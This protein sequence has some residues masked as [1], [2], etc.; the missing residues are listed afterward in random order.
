M[1]AV[2]PFEEATL[3]FKNTYPAYAAN[4]SR[5]HL[6][7]AEMRFFS[8]TLLPDLSLGVEVVEDIQFQINKGSSEQGGYWN[9]PQEYHD[10]IRL[11]SEQEIGRLK[12]VDDAD[13]RNIDFAIHPVKYSPLFRSKEVNETVRLEAF[14]LR[15]A[16]IQKASYLDQIGTNITCLSPITSKGNRTFREIDSAHGQ[17]K[18]LENC[19]SANTIG[20][21]CVLLDD[22]GEC[23]LRWRAFNPLSAREDSVLRK[24]AVMQSGWHCSSS[25]VLTWSDIE[26]G[27]SVSQNES[28][29]IVNGFFGGMRREIAREIGLNANEYDLSLFAYGREFKRA[30]KPQLFFVAKLRQISTSQVPDVIKKRKPPE[31]DEFKDLSAWRNNFLYIRQRLGVGIFENGFCEAL[32]QFSIGEE[33]TYE[34]YAVLYLL[35]RYLRGE[36]AQLRY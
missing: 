21:A 4:I 19:V 17:F 29:G 26:Q 31:R 1:G 9:P 13:Q 7:Y 23:L 28:A 30:G 14:G 11:K 8:S 3:D 25:G 35:S 22:D 32:K 27:I 5:T 6:W 15:T 24:L 10:H 20:V 33:F 16:V 12:S 36:S 34:G 2:S 18:A